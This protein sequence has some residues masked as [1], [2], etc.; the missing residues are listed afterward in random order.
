MGEGE[1]SAGSRKARAGSGAP[2]GTSARRSAAPPARRPPSQRQGF[3]VAFD[4]TPLF[5]EARNADREPEGEP[6]VDGET[7]PAPIVFTDGIGCDGY[8]WKYLEP[9]LRADR[10]VV[11]WH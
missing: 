6:G 7:V 10:P 1:S 11:H 2:G 4:H 3:A 8:V 9:E 5:Y